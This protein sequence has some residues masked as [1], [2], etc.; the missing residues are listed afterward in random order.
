MSLKENALHKNEGRSGMV[1]TNKT[2]LAKILKY[3][4]R[5]KFMIMVHKLRECQQW[6]KHIIQANLAEYFFLYLKF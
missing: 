6:K 1:L 4:G 2:V 5:K 3:F